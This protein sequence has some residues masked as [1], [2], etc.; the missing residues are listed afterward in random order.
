MTGVETSVEDRTQVIIVC[1][2]LFSC[3][4]IL[5]VSLVMCILRSCGDSYK[6]DQLMLLL[7]NHKKYP[8]RFAGSSLDSSHARSEVSVCYIYVYTSTRTNILCACVRV[9]V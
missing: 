3:P 1:V 8:R 9:C 6:Y 5:H 7:F 4:C 2:S